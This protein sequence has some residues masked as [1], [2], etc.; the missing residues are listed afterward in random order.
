M[1]FQS[2]PSCMTCKEMK[3]GSFEPI[4]RKIE[5]VDECLD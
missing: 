5:I 1:D 2:Y 3:K 4:E